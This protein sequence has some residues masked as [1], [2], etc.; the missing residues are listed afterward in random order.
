MRA[1]DGQQHGLRRHLVGAPRPNDDL[2]TA[3]PADQY[4]VSHLYALVCGEPLDAFRDHIA[5]LQ[6]YHENPP[7]VPFTRLHR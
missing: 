1:I 7:D 5:V 6:P 2:A 3:Y 4:S